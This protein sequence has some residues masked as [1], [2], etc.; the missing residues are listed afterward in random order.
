MAKGKTGPNFLGT[1]GW[2]KRP[3]AGFTLY[4]GALKKPEPTME[5]MLEDIEK[6]EVRDVQ[7]ELTLRKARERLGASTKEAAPPTHP[8]PKR[9]L[10]DPETGRISVD[11][12]EGELTYKDAI[13]T[14]ASIKGKSGQYDDA[15]SL[16]NVVKELSKNSQD[17]PAE[18]PKEYYV[19]PDSGIIIHDPDNG[20]LTL[21]EARTVSQSFQK[22]KT[23]SSVQAPGIYV[24][25]EGNVHELK[26]GQPI[27]VQKVTREPGKTFVF[28]GKDLIEQE[29][30]KPLVIKVEAQG[31]GASPTLPFPAI[32][33]D[34][35]PVYDKDGNPIYVD[36]EPQ[37]KWLNFQGEQK[38]SDERHGAL[39]GLV[40][41]VRENVPDGIQAILAAVSEAKGASAGTKPPATPQNFKC[42]DCGTEFSPPAGWAGQPIKC[43]NPV[44][45][46]EYSKEELLG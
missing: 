10:V 34:G 20:E 39:M 1:M 31:G 27:V 5:E 6:A 13:L 24:D 28:D 36:I 40:Q 42:G 19:D 44:C 8:N 7:K 16:I 29:A 17:K 14:S 3:I 43:P 45:G 30:G 32:S 23:D 18:K 11:E 26:P 4:T 25:G 37:L 15:I 33:R 9:Y 21:S 2:S 12:E 22:A 41:T 38:R 46:R 35:Q